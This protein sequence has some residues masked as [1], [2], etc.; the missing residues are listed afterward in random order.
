MTKA[1][2]NRDIC[3]QISAIMAHLTNCRVAW[4]KYATSP[5][6]IWLGHLLPIVYKMHL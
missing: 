5:P 3:Y 2:S 6:P 1:V 4:L